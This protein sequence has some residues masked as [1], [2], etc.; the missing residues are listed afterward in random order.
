MAG[1]RETQHVWDFDAIIDVN[2]PET[3]ELFTAARRC[4]GR[5]YCELNNLDVPTHEPSNQEISNLL[6]YLAQKA[7]DHCNMPQNI[8]APSHQDNADSFTS[9]TA[10]L[11]APASPWNPL[12]G[13]RSLSAEKTVPSSATVRSRLSNSFPP[14]E[15]NSR[16]ANHE[17]Q[18]F[19]QPQP[20]L[21]AGSQT[22]DAMNSSALAQPHFL[23]KGINPLTYQSIKVP[24]KNA[25]SS[26][27]HSNDTS[28]LDFPWSR[29]SQKTSITTPPF[30]GTPNRRSHETVIAGVGRLS[31]SSKSLKDDCSH[32][33]TY[34][35]VGSSAV[36]PGT[37]QLTYA[38]VASCHTEAARSNPEQVQ[39]LTESAASPATTIGS[40]IQRNKF[41]CTFEG[42]DKTF[43]WEWKFKDHLKVHT[44]EKS[45][46]C[47]DCNAYFGRDRDLIK[48]KQSQKHSKA[49]QRLSIQC[50]TSSMD[51]SPGTLS[52]AARGKS[53]GSFSHPSRG[54]RIG[55]AV[56]SRRCPLAAASSTSLADVG[57]D[58]MVVVGNIDGEADGTTQLPSDST[59][60]G[61]LAQANTCTSRSRSIKRI[62]IA[63]DIDTNNDDE[64]GTKALKDPN[65]ESFGASPISPAAGRSRNLAPYPL[66]PS[67]RSSRSSFSLSP[68]QISH[69]RRQNFQPRILNASE[70]VSAVSSSNV[71][72]ITLGPFH[73]SAVLPAAESQ[74]V[75][76]TLAAA[77]DRTTASSVM[78]D[79]YMQYINMDY[80]PLQATHASQQPILWNP[81]GGVTLGT[82]ISGEYSR[83]LPAHSFGVGSDGG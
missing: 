24:R 4:L 45:I 46:C 28:Q 1:A 20:A 75:D 38:E 30:H 5:F 32:S 66:I 73:R 61:N 42:C 26:I 27:A 29:E 79:D 40:N 43:D 56:G 59:A 22:S 31:T 67:S 54:R 34:E 80:D 60:G 55:S 7:L 77:D 63:S 19:S 72:S 8:Y 16:N 13:I 41:Y 74:S 3:Q 44:K 65:T 69:Q 15:G 70:S 11:Y 57:H 51:T 47:H 18:L 36:G 81:G 37:R 9:T 52:P 10:W 48:H 35:H 82:I 53:P 68:N 23:H 6:H 33:V 2:W 14:P 21:R 12:E 76:W 25:R 49:T 58:E 71:P 64:S 39:E 83:D 17:T 78:T 50:V 62:R